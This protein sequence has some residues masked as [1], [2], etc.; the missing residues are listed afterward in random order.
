MSATISHPT[1]PPGLEG[2][3]CGACHAPLGA[4]SRYCL[5]CGARQAG[6][7]TELLDLVA[8]PA[9]VS[10]APAAAPAPAASVVPAAPDA[11]PTAVFPVVPP[12]AAVLPA[13]EAPAVPPA[14][15]VLAAPAPPVPPATV[16]SLPAAG[17]R[18]WPFA[19][20]AVVLIALVV[21]L[22]LGRWLADGRDDASSGPQVIRIEGAGG[23]VTPATAAPAAGDVP[24]PAAGDAPAPVET[25]ATDGAPAPVPSTS[26]GAE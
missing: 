8:G 19:L 25:P 9:A 5:S 17:S 15:A 16:A 2:A 20:T 4:A 18:T 7:R 10:A 3:V 22:A 23:A 14:P 12:A 13:P 6:A 21:G 24:A 26:G 11:A 1:S